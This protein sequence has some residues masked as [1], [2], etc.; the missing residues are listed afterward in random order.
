MAFPNPGFAAA[1]RSDPSILGADAGAEASCSAF[2]GIAGAGVS[3]AASGAAPVTALWT[4]PAVL[5][6]AAAA[7]AL[8][9]RLASEVGV[10]G[11]V[12]APFAAAAAA[13]ADALALLTA[14]DVAPSSPLFEASVSFLPGALVVAAACAFWSALAPSAASPAITPADSPAE[15]AACDEA[16]AKAA[17]ALTAVSDRCNPALSVAS[18][19]GNL[20]VALLSDLSAADRSIASRGEA[21]FAV[22]EAAPGEAADDVLGSSAVVGLGSSAGG[23]LG[24]DTVARSGS[25]SLLAC[26]T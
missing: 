14:L 26:R 17:V 21:F 22:A 7:V 13:A 5:A 24:N 10:A 2:C 15:S 12:A 9:A 16:K 23:M 25:L 3:W 8:E 20:A 18:I 19:E 1:L 11:A 4:A 6:V